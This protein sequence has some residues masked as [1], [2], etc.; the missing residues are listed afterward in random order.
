MALQGHTDIRAGRW[1]AGVTGGGE[2]VKYEQPA[3][4]LQGACCLD[5][6]QTPHPTSAPQ[7]ASRHV[8]LGLV[9]FFVVAQDSLSLNR[10]FSKSY[11]YSQESLGWK[12]YLQSDVEAQRLSVCHSASV[13][14]IVTVQHLIACYCWDTLVLVQQ[15]ADKN[16]LCD[17]PLLH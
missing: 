10:G 16:E 6:P 5:P 3:L 14:L 7:S 1:Q 13:G 8:V 12:W 15:S 2:E 11:N 17:L 9:F 4:S